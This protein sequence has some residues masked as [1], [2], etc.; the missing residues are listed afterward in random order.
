MGVEQILMRP[1]DVR[2]IVDGVTR[3]GGTLSVEVRENGEVAFPQPGYVTAVATRQVFLQYME[4]ERNA[5]R[6]LPEALLSAERR[7][8]MIPQV[9]SQSPQNQETPRT[10]GLE[11]LGIP[12]MEQQ[13]PAASSTGLPNLDAVTSALANSGMRLTAASPAGASLP[14]REEGRN[15]NPGGPGLARGPSEQAR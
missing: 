2:A 12:P 5:G 3:S 9:Q 13:A 15:P 6:D 8:R 7:V 14:E 10:P 1:A 11:V 4:S